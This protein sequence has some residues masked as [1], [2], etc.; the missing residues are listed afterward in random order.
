MKQEEFQQDKY[1]E[2]K[3]KKPQIQDCFFKNTPTCPHTKQN[4]QK[5]QTVTHP[6]YELLGQFIPVMT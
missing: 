5:N 1:S 4:K 2:R 3:W 6:T